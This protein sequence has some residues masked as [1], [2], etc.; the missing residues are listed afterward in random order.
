MSSLLPTDTGKNRP[1]DESHTKWRMRTENPESCRRRAE[2]TLNMHVTNVELLQFSVSVDSNTGFSE[3]HVE[4]CR[5]V[6]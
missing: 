5:F 4:S 2:L 1:H 3:E 6:F